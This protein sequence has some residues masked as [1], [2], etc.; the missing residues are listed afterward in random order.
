MQLTK[1]SSITTIKAANEPQGD[2][3][4]YFPEVMADLSRP[5]PS[6]IGGPRW[7]LKP[8]ETAIPVRLPADLATWH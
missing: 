2:W 4:G 6:K 1:R 3:R 5:D 7:E 8:G